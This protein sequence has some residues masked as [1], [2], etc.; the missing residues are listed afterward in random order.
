MEAGVEKITF[1]EE[2]YRELFLYFG[3]ILELTSGRARLCPTTITSSSHSPHERLLDAEYSSLVSR[4][5]DKA[6]AAFTILIPPS[7]IF[8]PVCAIARK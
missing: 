6:A 7:C 8:A 4:V 1:G 3:A 2:E 5:R